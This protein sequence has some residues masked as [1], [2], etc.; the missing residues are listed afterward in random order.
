M[1]IACPDCGLLEDLPVLPR[2][3]AAVCRLCRGDLELTAGRSI[4]AALAC[5]L[6]TFFLL[7]PANLLPLMRIDMFGMHRE[8]VIGGGIAI[9]WNNGWFLLAGLSGI[10][11]V[12]IPF[13]R[14]GLLSAVLGALRLDF[15]PSWL[16]PAFRWSLWL[17][18]W[19]M[20]DVFLLASFVGYYRLAHVAQL[21]V[22]VQVGG[23]IFM[24]AAFL[25]MLSRALLD[26]RTVWRAI[27]PEAHIHPGEETLS[28]TTCDLVQ[29]VTRD[30]EACPRCGA[31]L[32]TRKTDSIRRTL[33]L[34]AAAFVLFFPANIYPMNV[35]HQL[36]TVQAYT[37]FDGIRD[38]F[39]SG[40]WPLGVLITCTSI[41][42]PVGKIIALGWFVLSATGRST[43]HL[44]L[45]A[46]VF[47]LIAELGR[48]SKTDPFTIVFFVPLLNMGVFAT[49]SAGWGATAFIMMT[50]LT[51]IAVDTF[52]PRLM[53]DVAEERRS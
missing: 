31:T 14:F 39:M 48:W 40:L 21:H 6:A 33:A 51:M 27:A 50:F 44:V 4:T 7:F 52:D 8:N 15:R 26:R 16:G 23:E 30:G 1:T 41:L 12:V 32:Y 20:L 42:V 3:S 11:V 28:C 17:N 5:A 37:I 53:W 19:A 24:G 10:L 34:L 47:R 36:G 35:S 46:K 29:P 22:S 45:K 25:T 38:L 9:L 43:G 13:V 2:G 18:R 49:A